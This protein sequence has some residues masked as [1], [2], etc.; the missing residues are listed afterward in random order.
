MRLDENLSG[1]IGR[2]YAARQDSVAWNRLGPEIMGAL[3]ARVALMTTVDLARESFLATR[4][5]GP[6]DTPFAQGLADYPELWASDPTLRWA[7]RHPHARFCASDRTVEGDYESHPFVAWNLARFNASHWYVCYSAPEDGLSHSLSIH[8]PAA[9]GAASRETLRKFR[10][11]FEHVD[12]AARI[13]LRPPALD[14]AG[15]AVA[16][17]RAGAISDCT[18]A[19]ETTLAQ[20]D[21]LTRADG[22]LSARAPREAER[23]ERLLALALD[24][25]RNGTG[26][27]SLLVER[28]GGGTPPWLVTL[29]PTFADYG[30]IGATQTGVQVRWREFRPALPDGARLQLVLDLSPREAEVLALLVAGHSLESAACRLGISR[31]TARVHLQAIFAKTRTTRQAEL[32]QLCARLEAAGD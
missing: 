29:R 20:S 18:A 30:G 10:L 12:N 4:F 13:Q 22:R 21:G 31:N 16:L 2:V 24:A 23:L 3:G 14:Q 15:A 28:G 7:S 8:I 1:L 32:L 17:D 27:S 5:F 9:Q 26:A 25:Q 6:D 11:L 19:A